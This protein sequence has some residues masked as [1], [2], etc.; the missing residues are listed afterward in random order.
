MVGALILI[1]SGFTGRSIIGVINGDPEPESKPK[2]DNLNSLLNQTEQNFNDNSS[3]SGDSAGSGAALLTTI[4][5]HAQGMGLHV[6]E[7]PAYGGVHPVHVPGSYHYKKFPGTN[8]GRAID[9]SG[10]SQQMETFAHW[11]LD[12]FGN[13]VTELFWRGPGWVNIK[14]GQHE[15]FDFVSGHTDHV[16]IAI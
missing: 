16:H 15:P 12:T 1:S 7:N 5:K 10:T 11:V 14:N 8:V 9:V 6:G 3:G 13:V 2:N 4:A